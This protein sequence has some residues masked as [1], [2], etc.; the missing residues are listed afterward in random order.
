MKDKKVVLI[1]IIFLLVVLY[2]E[3]LWAESGSNQISDA[4]MNQLQRVFA[5]A[6]F[7]E[8]YNGVLPEPKEGIVIHEIYKAFIQGKEN[9]YIFKISSPGY[10]GDIVVLIALSSIK[11]QIIGIQIL[12]QNETPSVGDLITKPDFLI[13]FLNKPIDA[14]FKLG[15]DIKAISGATISS[16]AVVKACQEAVSFLKT[17]QTEKEND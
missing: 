7:F 9:G 1:T 16:S 5:G 10:H 17:I 4:M 13:Q 14:K 3:V 11:N 8:R 12:E 2:V 15:D 6:D